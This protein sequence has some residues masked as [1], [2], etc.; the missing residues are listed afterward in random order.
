MYECTMGSKD[1]D[2][3][4]V[5]SI[6]IDFGT[7]GFGS[8]LSLMSEVWPLVLE[9]EILRILKIVVTV[10]ISNSYVFQFPWFK[11]SYILSF[12]VKIQ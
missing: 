3:L 6:N 11:I 12:S 9:D 2:W 7:C 1:A 4:V 8:T 10:T 5:S